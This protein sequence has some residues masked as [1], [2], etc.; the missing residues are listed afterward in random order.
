VEVIGFEVAITPHF[1]F[2]YDTQKH[3]RMQQNKILKN[4]NYIDIQR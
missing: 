3:N 2:V 4:V 1:S